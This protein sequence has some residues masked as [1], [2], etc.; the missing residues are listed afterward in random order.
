MKQAIATAQFTGVQAMRAAGAAAMPLRL[1]DVPSQLLRDLDAAKRSPQY[2][3]IDFTAY[4]EKLVAYAS[5]ATAFDARLLAAERAGDESKLR[6]LTAIAMVARDA[7]Y[8]PGGLT[9]NRYWH[10]IDR[11]VAPLPEVNFAAYDPEHRDAMVGEALSRL[12]ASVDR[13]MSA[14]ES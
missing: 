13:A 3:G 1:A 2:A 4:R 6:D 9:Y 12:I 11:V 5:A 10:T 8:Q 7:F 14:L